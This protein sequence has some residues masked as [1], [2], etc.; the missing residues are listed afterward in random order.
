MTPKSSSVQRHQFL[1]SLWYIR[2]FLGAK[3]CS[4]HVRSQVMMLHGVIELRFGLFFRILLF[5][6]RVLCF[7]F[8]SLW[9][10]LMHKPNLY[11]KKENDINI[12]ITS[13]FK[14]NSS[15]NSYEGTL[16]LKSRFFQWNA[17]MIPLKVGK[18]GGRAMHLRCPPPH[19][20]SLNLC[21]RQY[22]PVYFCQVNDR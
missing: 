22:I 3:I 7:A 5:A 11:E 4:S 6:F 9:D 15:E 12:K 21:S 18:F 10:I 8:S 17:H 2:T 20:L 1:Y 13:L 16:S 19:G 14:E